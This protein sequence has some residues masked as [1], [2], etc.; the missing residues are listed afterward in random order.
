MRHKLLH[1]F[2]SDYISINRTAS[3]LERQA[4]MDWMDTCHAGAA[5]ISRDNF[6]KFKEWDCFS[7]RLGG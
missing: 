4:I 5:I 2:P 6:S 7:K 3:A 1:E